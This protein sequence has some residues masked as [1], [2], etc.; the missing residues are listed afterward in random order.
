MRLII[1]AMVIL[2]LLS[3][4]AGAQNCRKGIPCGHTCISASKVCHIGSSPAPVAQ[5][6]PPS[7]APAISP[8]ARSFVGAPASDT[9]RT[10]PAPGEPATTAGEYPWVGSFADGVYFQ[11][12][13]PLAQDLAPAN[14]RF[15]RTHQDAEAAGFRR[16]RTPGC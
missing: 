8:P 6:A 16:S 9:S 3:R 7:S 14:R 1:A 2:I 13:C 4:S 11:A 5:P 10:T 12:S 15:F